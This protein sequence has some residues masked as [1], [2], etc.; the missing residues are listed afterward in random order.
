MLCLYWQRYFFDLHI[1]YKIGL[2]FSDPFLIVH[3]FSCY[4][5]C[6][7]SNVLDIAYYESSASQFLFVV[8]WNAEFNKSSLSQNDTIK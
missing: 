2:S 3:L 5:F 4:V 6:S 8:R 1:N 7:L